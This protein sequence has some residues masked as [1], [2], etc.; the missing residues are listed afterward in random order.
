MHRRLER[1]LCVKGLSDEAL[2]FDKVNALGNANGC[3]FH[4]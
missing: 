3:P 4:S 2:L 1:K